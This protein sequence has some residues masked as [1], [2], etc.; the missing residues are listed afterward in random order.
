MLEMPLSNA[1]SNDSAL[2]SRL[3]RLP[4][5]HRELAETL[6]ARRSQTGRSA[7]AVAPIRA[8]HIAGSPDRPD[9]TPR[10]PANQTGRLPLSAS[11][12]FFSAED[13]HPADVTYRFVLD[14]ARFADE[15]GFESIWLPERHFNE[16][17]APYPNPAILAAAIAAT[18][19]RLQIR[20]GSV[21]LPLRDPVTVAE[22]WAML[23]G[24]APGRVGVA[25]ASGWHPDDFVLDPSSFERR[26]DVL[27]DRL[28]DVRH[29][30]AGGR[31]KRPNGVGK[32]VETR[33]F[34]RVERP[35]PVW[36]TSS[37]NEETW[38]RAARSG[39]NVLTGLL[40]QNLAAVQRLTNIY[41]EER[42]RAGLDPGSGRVTLMV[43][44]L[45]GSSAEVVRSLVEAPLSEY[46]SR[47]MNL[48]AKL[49]QSQDI[50]FDV[51][52]VTAADRQTLL[53]FGVERYIKRHGLFGTPAEC[54]ERA[55][56]MR[57][58]GVDEIAHLL[59][60]GVDYGRVLDHLTYLDQFR[61]LIGC[62]ETSQIEEQHV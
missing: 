32:E 60:F 16:F 43:H 14:A 4:S 25:F 21:V 50:G 33:T 27:S 20:A 48:F 55:L 10:R 17:G 12:F 38:R 31:I 58:A 36:L 22:D 39:C 53:R 6:L 23:E 7:D 34:P 18:T 41:R 59:D 35:I 56:A 54:A 5:R 61:Q 37:S 51:E 19:S 57:E 45:M 52:K 8:G 2:K 42:E 44:T 29:L 3:S 49:G 62:H 40:E 9:L 1:N 46:L 26:R 30:W 47:H 11:L 15:H 24:L 28:S 13:S